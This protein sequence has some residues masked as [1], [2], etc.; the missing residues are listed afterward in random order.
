[1]TWFLTFPSALQ[2]CAASDGYN[3]A[4]Q[5]CAASDAI[6]QPGYNVSSSFRPA[7]VEAL[8][9]TYPLL[10]CVPY[11]VH[12]HGAAWVPLH[13]KHDVDWLEWLF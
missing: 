2:R 11:Y 7:I 6:R 13:V 8:T 1:M 10:A 12:L 9:H 4:L 3:G 5:G